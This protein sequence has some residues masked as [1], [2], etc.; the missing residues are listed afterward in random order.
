MR[1]TRSA[2]SPSGWVLPAVVV[3]AV[4]AAGGLI[5]QLGRGGPTRET[6]APAAGAE[7]A[8]RAEVHMLRRQVAALSQPPQQ[9]STPERQPA[10][11]ASVVKPTVALPL[12]ADEIRERTEGRAELIERTL[13]T[14]A[15]DL[16]W[17]QQAERTI[18]QVV[19]TDPALKD[20]R[21]V[22]TECRSTLCRIETGHPS[23]RE[24]A[25]F[26]QAL[27]NRLSGFPSGTMRLQA[28]GAGDFRTV[29]YLARDGHRVPR[30]L[31]EPA[32]P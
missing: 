26:G 28:R 25:R 4:A 8:L 29:I 21:L 19:K 24:G 12:S 1:S 2:A 20:A 23:R 18:A 3:A 30:E 32:M 13:R 15:V 27:P 5:F 7:E 6:P 11:A 14:E 17:A 22:S 9:L 10:A 16:P 31:E